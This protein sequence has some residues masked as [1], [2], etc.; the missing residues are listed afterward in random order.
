MSGTVTLDLINGC[1][2]LVIVLETDLPLHTGVSTVAMTPRPLQA[3]A[4]LASVGIVLSSE[5]SDSVIRILMPV[6]LDSYYQPS[7]VTLTCVGGTLPATYWRRLDDSSPGQRLDLVPPDDS[8]GNDQITF[9]VTPSLEGLYY[10]KIGNL[11]S[12]NHLEI[13]GEFSI[14]MC[15][16]DRSVNWV[17]PLLGVMCNSVYGCMTVAF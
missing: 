16:A 4:F 10:C 17:V 7:K 9:E 3:L 15:T 11:T 14:T 5:A 6:R 8:S 2:Q 13:V 12:V 1:I